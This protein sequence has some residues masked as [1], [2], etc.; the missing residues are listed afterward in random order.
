MI[1]AERA[2]DVTVVTPWFPT[3]ERP[4][5]GSF[6][7]DWTLA[8]V[9]PGRATVV[10]LQNVEPGTPL[11]TAETTGPTGRVVRVPV[12]VAPRSPRA[13]VARAQR[14]ALTTALEADPDLL[15][16]RGTV[17]AHVGAPTGWAVSGLLD[18]RVTLV[19]TEHAS[20][21]PTVLASPET[22]RQYA[23][24]LDR[25]ARLLC[26]GEDEARLVRATLPERAERV[27]AVGNPVDVTRF[28]PRPWPTGRLGRW[29]S[30]ANL[31]PGKGVE[32][33]VRAFG[34]WV[35]APQDHLT[36]V[37]DGPLRPELERAVAEL[38]LVGRV[39]FAGAVAPS[40]VPAVL[41]EQDVLVHLSDRETFGL[42]PL[43]G[44]LAGLPVVA[45]ASGGPT[46][47]LQD[48]AA[49]GVARL[50]PVRPSAAAV[51]RAVA[52]LSGAHD[53]AA[54]AARADVAAR[55]GVDAFARRARR[56]LAGAPP[57][58]VPVPGAA[59]AVTIGLEVA[60]CRALDDLHDELLRAGA[61]VV[62]LTGSD[63]EA[64]SVDRRLRPHVVTAGRRVRTGPLRTAVSALS[65]CV[66]A[67]S[68]LPVPGV[69]RAA[70]A[71]ARR[72]EGLS[73]RLQSRAAA[74]TGTERTA[75]VRLDPEA[76]ATALDRGTVPDQVTGV[77]YS[78]DVS[79]LLAQALAPRHGVVAREV[80]PGA[81]RELAAELSRRG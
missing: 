10:H 47:T 51:A 66:D 43:E 27:H 36:V 7:R 5:H 58:P 33:A 39:T 37:G 29:V 12:P 16:T 23:E 14:R 25:S 21:L 2:A 65:A 9:P 75:A 28:V 15:P 67:A 76:V 53:A 42:A 41:R 8:C 18:P 4:H 69:P 19:V 22:R 81:A 62:H 45:T 80:P 50:V 20:Y 72:A 40:D 49:R 31:V 73:R 35:S 30:V 74:R 57:D 13:E 24:M 68:R 61:G 32:H 11:E 17:H 54:A 3:P 44:L 60:D 55:F 64:A 52:E 34:A 71:L 6:V 70:R 59:V 79:G 77:V 46:R 48:A 26:V 63:E 78:G 56:A 1:P 38:G